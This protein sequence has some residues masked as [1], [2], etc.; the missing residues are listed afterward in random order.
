M[1]LEKVALC[2]RKMVVRND[3]ILKFLEIGRI[4]TYI[5]WAEKQ[6]SGKFVELWEINA[7]KPRMV[8]LP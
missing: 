3:I 7:G 1:L 6:E 8:L 4:S 2:P 5:Y